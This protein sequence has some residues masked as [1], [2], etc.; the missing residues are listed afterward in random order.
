MNTD[1]DTAIDFAY[2]NRRGIAFCAKMVRVFEVRGNL[3]PG[4]VNA[5]LRIKAGR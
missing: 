2:A 3:T 5:L 1:F 4:Q